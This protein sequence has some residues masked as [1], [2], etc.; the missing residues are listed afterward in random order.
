MAQQE[1]ARRLRLPPGM[2]PRY[3]SREEAAAYLG[4]S[5]DTFDDEVASGMWPAARRRGSKGARL[6]W[7]RKVLDAFADQAAGIAAP[8]PHAMTAPPPVQAVEATVTP[9]TQQP[10]LT[11]EAAALRG[12]TNAPPR[13]RRKHGQPA[14]V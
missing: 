10:T 2:E 6:T 4:V 12:I 9:I 5:P 7:D 11:A 14:Q 8:P 13:H 1:P 3:L